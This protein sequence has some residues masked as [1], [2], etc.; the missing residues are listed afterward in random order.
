M[1]FTRHNKN[2]NETA[3]LS[4]VAVAVVETGSQLCGLSGWQHD[5]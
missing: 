3:I 4:V 2:N 1:E 5:R